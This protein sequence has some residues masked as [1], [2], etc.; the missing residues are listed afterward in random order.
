LQKETEESVA[1]YT[2]PATA[3]DDP[4]GAATTAVTGSVPGPAAR[5]SPAAAA[6]IVVVVVV[7]PCLTATSLTPPAAALGGPLARP[8][9]PTTGLHVLVLCSSPEALTAP[10]VEHGRGG[11]LASMVVVDGGGWLAWRARWKRGVV[12]WPWPSNWKE[13]VFYIYIYIYIYI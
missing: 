11:A 9:P 1:T 8:A 7:L 3:D 13:Y 6:T 12:W 2:A 4:L 10:A 5:L